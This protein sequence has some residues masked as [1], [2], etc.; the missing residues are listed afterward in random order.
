MSRLKVGIVGATGYGGAELIRLL[1]NHPYFHIYSVYSSSQEHVELAEVYPHLAH[2]TYTLEQI[3]PVQMAKDIDLVFTATPSG[4]SSKLVPQFVN[5]GLKVIDLSGDF[6]LNSEELYKTWYKKEPASQKYVQ[7]SVYG[8][9][10]WFN[11]NV[12]S[13]TFV[14]NPGCYPTATLLGLAP[15]VKAQMVKEDSIIIDAKSGLSGAGRA[16]SHV[17]HYAEINENMKIY[18]VNEHQHIPEIE[19]V[20]KQWNE[21][22]QPITFSTHLVPMTRGIMTTIYCTLKGSYTID[23]LHNLYT[24][25]YQS[26][27][28]VRVRK[29]GT[30]P[31]TKEVSGSNYCD[32]GLTVDARTNRMTIVSVIDNLVKGAAGQAI[33]NA[34]VMMDFEQQTG[35]HVLPV[36]P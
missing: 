12:Q 23:E 3:D 14:A 31:S 11:E 6:R 24:N 9:T 5:E 36:Y 13:S 29:Q 1:S 26:S 15:V 34:N 16:L 17:S 33:Q 35:L 25:S 30:F 20:L 8:L 19:Q 32:L 2:L 18:K 27:P 22:V 4:I 10:E 21:N 28:F 7:Q